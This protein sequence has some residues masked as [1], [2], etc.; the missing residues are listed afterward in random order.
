MHQ[1][2]KW[3]KQLYIL[4]E[5]TFC[6]L[7]K[8]LEASCKAVSD[9]QRQ[10]AKNDHI[11]LERTDTRATM[12]FQNNLKSFVK[13]SFTTIDG[14]EVLGEDCEQVSAADDEDCS[15]QQDRPLPRENEGGNPCRGIDSN[16]CHYSTLGRRRRSGEQSLDQE[17]LHQNLFSPIKSRSGKDV[18]LRTQSVR[19]NPEPEKLYDYI[20]AD[21]T[22]RGYLLKHGALRSHQRWFVLKNFHLYS[23]KRESDE[24]EK[25]NPSS[26]FKLN[27]QVQLL[28]LGHSN[29]G[30]SFKITTFDKQ[31]SMTLIAPTA[32]IRE[33]WI[34][35][36]NV[37]INM[38][39]I[40]PDILKK[41]NSVH[42]GILTVTRHGHSKKCHAI[43]VNHLLFFLK[44]PIDPTPISYVSIKNSRIK[45]IA[46]NQDYS[47]VN[48][49][50]EFDPR[51]D[52]VEDCSLAI[53]PR[54]SLDLDPIYITLSNQQDAD[55]WFHH[56]SIV[57]GLDQSCGTKFER[58]LTQTMLNATMA[59]KCQSLS[60]T[61]ETSDTSSDLGVS[62]YWKENS[63]LLY[64]D[65]P[66]TAPLTSLPNETLKSEAIELFKSVLL[67]TQA[68]IEPVAIDYHVCLLQNCLGKFLKNPE[69]RNEFYA[70]LIKQSTYVRHR[71]YSTKLSSSSSSSGCSSI[72]QRSSI[73][74]LTPSANECQLITDL[75]V[76]QSITSENEQK[77]DARSTV[78]L[79]QSHRERSDSSP[80]PEELSL[81]TK[82]EI[83]QAM[84]IISLA[85]SLNLPR[86]RTRW[87]LLQHL[88]KFSNPETELGKYALYALKA[89]ERT[90]SN[91]SRDNVPSRT[92]IMSILMRNPYDH[93]TPHSLP[94]NFEDSSYIIVGVDGSTTVEECMVSMSKTTNIRQSS[95]SD[96]YLFA[97]DPNEGNNELHILEAQRKILDVVGWWE[98]TF[99]LK[100]S[101]R[102]Q[103]TKV[104]K[105][106]CKKRLILRCE[107]D[108][109]E[110][111]RL[112]IVHQLNNEVASGKIPISD[113]LLIELSAIMTQMTFGEF[114]K[115]KDDSKVV[116]RILDKISSNFMPHL[117]DAQSR[118]RLAI[119]VFERWGS[120]SGRTAQDCVRVYLNCIRKLKLSV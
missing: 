1:S 49:G 43:L 16:S 82:C 46:D 119:Q 100:N 48:Q 91:G 87:L 75:D 58:V 27:S 80:Q 73:N 34:K 63:V 53:Y 85:V 41:S 84:Q 40:E 22:K 11:S 54:Y 78:S 51:S 62:C 86:G 103:N 19:K 44:S 21:L 2:D 110:Q 68:P 20:S 69:L 88:Q 106:Y 5:E 13:P 102:F 39:D 38:S 37:A 15:K 66:I 115:S 117:I 108:E 118:N 42:E 59:K 101:G 4:A 24:T 25:L 8:E 70:Q 56:L 71:C 60:F 33:G 67:F 93:S 96:F 55:E 72:N 29:E 104:I 36:L 112:L 50:A 26:Q 116:K 6:S 14:D 35:I 7:T 79:S 92:E 83:L 99:K 107:V 30:Y 32:Q 81:P 10:G 105:I 90:L 47:P 9:L 52:Q 17:S 28:C 45:E 94:I 64:T 113:A 98:Q 120:L 74:S 95:S 77:L 97:N 65:K 3:E 109:S 23:Y 111:E 114:S 61:S 89:I 31:H 76:L 18:I 57:S 12:N